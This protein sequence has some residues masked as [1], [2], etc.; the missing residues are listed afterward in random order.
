VGAVIGAALALV[1][2]A[3]SAQAASFEQTGKFASR[4]G[5]AAFDLLVLRPLS[6]SALL[7]GSAF[8][9][10]SAPLVAP[11][12]TFRT[13]DVVEAVHPAWSVFVYAPYEY[14]VLRDLGDF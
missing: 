6:A 12:E 2:H 1:V 11:Y 10:A 13:G 9:V 14:T 7:A 4:F 5:E 3:D 8:F